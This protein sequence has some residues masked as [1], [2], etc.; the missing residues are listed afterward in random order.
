M[1]GDTRPAPQR[2]VSAWTAHGTVSRHAVRVSNT[3]ARY[4]SS[5]TVDFARFVRTDRLN[6]P[7]LVHVD[8]LASELRIHLESSE[9]Q[10]LILGAN[11]P[12]ASSA[13]IQ[14]A[15][16]TFARAAGFVDESKG[17]FA[18]YKTRGLRPDYFLPLGNTG[19]LLEV[20]RGKTTINN[21]DL[22]DFWKCH[23]CE[24]ANFLF[25]LVPREL[26]QNPSMRPR[27]EFNTVR[28]RLETFF[29]PQ[30]YTNV[31]GLWLFGY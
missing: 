6:M 28:N 12:G 19:V 20:E 17:L 27:R 3:S 13:S 10:E 4:D 24:Q 26:R 14:S 21:M 18:T 15:C 22:L 7:E 16:L 2:G 9:T 5:V 30:N 31:F 29:A 23:L 11:V 25:L 8:A 1:W